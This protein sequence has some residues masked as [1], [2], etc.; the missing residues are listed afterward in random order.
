MPRFC[1]LY[2][3]KYFLTLLRLII[4]IIENIMNTNFLKTLI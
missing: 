1:A 3:K 2:N 4:F